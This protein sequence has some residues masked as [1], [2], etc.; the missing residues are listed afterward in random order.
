MPDNE[1]N[2]AGKIA[3]I[4]PGI[5]YTPDMPLL[6]FGRDLLMLAGYTDC[7][8]VVFSYPGKAS[9][10]GNAQKM[11]EAAEKLYDMAS[12]SLSDIDF[13]RYDDVFFVSKSIGTVIAAAYAER[14]NLNSKRIRHVLYTPLEYT[15]DYH[16]KNAI[17]FTGTADPWVEHESVMSLASREGIEM[18]VYEGADHSLKVRDPMRDID[19]LK[20]VITKTKTFI[21]E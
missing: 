12:E 4:L 15:F 2:E 5:G 18:N 17:G 16:P 9:I 19:I 6:Y 21:F 1:K 10:K 13:S 8:K 20:D 11:K 14:N 7:R 3:I